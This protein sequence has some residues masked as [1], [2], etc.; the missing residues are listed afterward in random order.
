[1]MTYVLPQECKRNLLM[2]VKLV[3][4]NL[5]LGLKESKD[6]VDEG[7]IEGEEADVVAFK[8]ALRDLNII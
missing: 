5:H 7:I 4:D 8:A 3:H 6:M 1:M 2:C